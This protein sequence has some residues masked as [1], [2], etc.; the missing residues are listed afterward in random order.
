MIRLAVRVRRADAE[1]VLAELLELAPSGR[2]GDRGRRRRRVR[3]L[4]RRPASCP[5]CPTL[6]GRGG[7]TRSWRSTPTRSP[8]TGPTRWKHFHRPIV[9]GDRLPVRPPWAEPRRAP[10]VDGDRHRPGPGVRHR[11]ARHDAHVPRAA[12]RAA[13]RRARSPTRLRLGRAGDRGGEARLGARCAA[14]DF[15]VASVE[16]TRE[17]AA[18]N[19]VAVTAARVDLRARAAPGAPTGAAN[20]LRPLLLTV[21]AAASSAPRTG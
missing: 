21:A 17:N 10:G 11:R 15:E 20:L 16:A 9:V 13:S 18:V 8:T 3:G 4:R 19:G 2:G 1:L 6:R 12:A 14:V 7:R 5:R